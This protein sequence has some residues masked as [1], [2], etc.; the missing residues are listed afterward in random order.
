MANVSQE[1]RVE[2]SQLKDNNDDDENVEEKDKKVFINHI[3][4]Y[5]G[6]H[7]ARVSQIRSIDK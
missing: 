4:S 7:I 1:E 2:S 3:D 5:H 6:K